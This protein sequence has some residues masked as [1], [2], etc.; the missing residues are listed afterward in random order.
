SDLALNLNLLTDVAIAPDILEPDDTFDVP[1]ELSGPD[2]QKRRGQI[3]D[4]YDRNSFG[5]VSLLTYLDEAYYFVPMHIALQLQK[6]GEY[7][8]AL[9][10][11]RTV[12]DYTCHKPDDPKIWYGLHLRSRYPTAFNVRQAGF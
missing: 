3:A 8:P 5:P 11:F 6:S 1:C 7:E 2:L 12:Y 9:A 10:W 4:A